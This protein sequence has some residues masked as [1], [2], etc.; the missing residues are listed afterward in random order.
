MSFVIGHLSFV[1]LK[2]YDVMGNEVATLVD[3]Y[4]P[5][6][7][8]EVT[9][10]SAALSSGVYYYRLSAGDFIQTKSMLLIK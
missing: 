8:Y 1:S 3:E 7:N 6:G 9:F 4:K 2:V 10:N 5:A